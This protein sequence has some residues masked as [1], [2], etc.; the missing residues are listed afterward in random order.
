MT[1]NIHKNYI[2]KLEELFKL[3]SMSNL[4][5]LT[6]HGNPIDTIPGFRIYVIGILPPLKRLDTVLISG[7]EYDNAKWI[8][9]FKSGKFPQCE[10]PEQPPAIE[11][12]KKEEQTL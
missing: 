8:R 4:K 6:I 12:P 1:L 10:N 11:E 2:S 7:K 3:Q 9:T 5:S